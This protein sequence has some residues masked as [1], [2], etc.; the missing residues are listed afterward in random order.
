MSNEEENNITD[1]TDIANGNNENITS[2][3]DIADIVDENNNNENTTNIADVVD[4]GTA[5][6]NN[7]NNGFEEGKDKLQLTI[8]TKQNVGFSLPDDL[9]DD[10]KPYEMKTEPTIHDLSLLI[11]DF[12]QYNSILSLNTPDDRK[13]SPTSRLFSGKA[14]DDGIYE[15]IFPIP[16]EKLVKNSNYIRTTKYTIWSF[17]PLNLI[18]Q[19]R[20]LYNIYFLFA[21]FS[22]L[23][24]YSA[25][26]PFTQIFPLLLVLS[27]TALKDGY[28]DYKRYLSD[29]ETNNIKYS[30]FR[31]GYVDL[32]PSKDIQCGDVVIL[33]KGDKIPAD[34]LLIGS[35]SEE[36]TCYIET[37]DLDG[38]TNLKRRTALSQF[39]GIRSLDE[40]LRVKCVIHCEKPND[41]LTSFDGNI[42]IEISK[43]ANKTEEKQHDDPFSQPLKSGIQR[44]ASFFRRKKAISNLKKGVPFNM[45]NML[46]RG[47]I[48]R[49][50]D[51]IYG[52]VIYSGQNTKVYQ[53]LKKS[54]MKF[55]KMEKKLNILILYIFVFNI[56]IL[57]LTVIMNFLQTKN[58][59]EAVHLDKPTTN[60]TAYYDE[61]NRPIAGIPQPALIDSPHD[62]WYVTEESY[63]KKPD[64]NYPDMIIS[65]I[66]S[67]FA[68]YTYVIPISLFVSL[69]IVRFL[70]A[71]SM[72]KDK[73]MTGKQEIQHNLE[74]TN[75]KSKVVRHLDKDPNLLS[76]R[77]SIY[78]SVHKKTVKK[79]EIK[80]LN[81]KVNNSNLNEELGTVEYIFSDKTGTLTR[82]DMQLSKWFVS[83]K[84]FN[85]IPL[86]KSLLERFENPECSAEEKNTIKEFCRAVAMCNETIPSFEP[87]TYEIIYESQSPDESALVYGIKTEG[88]NLIE[89]N[90]SSVSIGMWGSEKASSLRMQVEENYEILMVFEFNSDRKRMS[91]VLRRPDNRIVLY[92]KGADDIMFGRLS[93]D[94]Q[95][96]DP[97][98]IQKTKNALKTFSQDGLRVLLVATKEL[99]E[100]QYDIFYNEYYYANQNINNRAVAVEEVVSKIE[101]DLKLLG[102]T[103]IEDR[104]QDKV[105]E[106]IDYILKSGIRFWL[107]TGDK[108]ETAINIG[109]SSKLLSKDFNM[110][111]LNATSESECDKKLDNFIKTLK[112]NNSWGVDHTPKESINKGYKKFLGYFKKRKQ[113]KLD[114]D[115]TKRLEKIWEKNALIVDG[116]TL[117]FIFGS[118]TE[119]EEEAQNKQS[120]NKIAPI[121]PDENKDV[122][123]KEEEIENKGSSFRYDQ[124]VMTSMQ[125]K[126]LEIGTRCHSVICCRVTPIQKARVVKLVKIHLKKTTLAIGDGAND[127]SMIKAAD[128]GI[129]IMGKEGAQAVKASDYAFKEFKFLKRLIFIHG[130]YNYIR[131]TKILLYSFYKNIVLI[132]PQIICGFY[133]YWSGTMVYEEMF[134]TAYNVLMTSIPGP[135]LACL[136]RDLPVQAIYNNPPIYLETLKGK[137]WNK[138]L[139]IHWFA[140]AIYQGCM[141]FYMVFLTL[142]DSVIKGD[143]KTF[144]NGYWGQCY[145]METVVLL[146]V[147]VKALMITDWMT[148]ITYAGIGIMLLFHILIMIVVN[149]IYYADEGS[150]YLIFQAPYL[151][152][153]FLFMLVVNIL[154]DFAILY[155]QKHLYPSDTQIILENYKL[156][157]KEPLNYE[158]SESEESIESIESSISSSSSYRSCIDNEGI[159]PRISMSKDC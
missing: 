58:D 7:E 46:L 78:R 48:L 31:N 138:K 62:L 64:S 26:N 23:T 84:I 73:K 113:P 53:N 109:T 152:L 134:L 155:Y 71:F 5:D 145:I 40:L 3:T 83:G 139:F 154:P 35:S 127:V 79:V 92:C 38:E 149:Y 157:K 21:A 143:G 61:N 36:G 66:L 99:T 110:M 33:Q 13:N 140:L 27:V 16:E 12:S 94:P 112:D 22:T 96:N 11:D 67:Y 133:T 30:I 18:S 75:D 19:F 128:V 59:G 41:N 52:M 6:R 72:E 153:M 17:L 32:I 111:I 146:T 77:A 45:E 114:P 98:Y 104:L 82:N 43:K 107:L 10:K 63:I 108:Q 156:Q 80:K 65:S 54:G 89:R 125:R 50:T 123:K 44:S 130:H 126:F 68:L 121:T 93:P 8:K 14:D 141:S 20:R 85:R 101:K 158:E 135:V 37:S 150:I 39:S 137:Y 86:Q 115:E 25:L 4:V 118:T 151:L 100:E 47:S 24:K 147:L 116:G 124:N 69:E 87:K 159:E 136:E 49:N 97:E 2:I 56:A 34:L 55:S 142:N 9:Q 74:K 95:I 81:M 76:S 42:S 105:P 103:A 91:V 60:L 88:V 15:V 102:A 131:I 144:A 120:N 129:G 90:R 51:C 28:E 148:I 57:A 106:T 119:A 70:Q 29:K 1:I 122:E 117:S 132:I